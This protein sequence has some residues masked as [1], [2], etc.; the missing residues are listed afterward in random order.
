MKLKFVLIQ[1]LLATIFI[2]GCSLNDQKEDLIDS[3]LANS[4]GSYIEEDVSNADNNTDAFSDYEL[5]LISFFD[6]LKA[7][8]DIYEIVKNYDDL[9]GIYI[10]ILSKDGDILYH[11]DESLIGKNIANELPLGKDI[12]I[13]AKAD[14]FETIKYVYNQ[15]NRK[16]LFT[17]INEE[18]V[19]ASYEDK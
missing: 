9:T 5:Q 18:I 6:E 2:T 11:P 3:D 14:Q 12:I 7:S 17:I 8:D 19:V 10:Y 15:V 16:V 1:L 13:D 4:D